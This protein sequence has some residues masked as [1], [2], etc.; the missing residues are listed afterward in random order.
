MEDQERYRDYVAQLISRREELEVQFD[1]FLLA[2]SDQKPDTLR[3]F[4]KRNA[5]IQVFEQEY[6]SQAI[7]GLELNPLYESCA[8]SDYVLQ[9]IR[10]HKFCTN[11]IGLYPRDME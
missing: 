1:A 6:G 2:P 5:W 3:C 11:V 10:L 4:A 8:Y 9:F 7:A